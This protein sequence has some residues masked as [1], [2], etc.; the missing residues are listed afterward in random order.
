[1]QDKK[2]AE[3]LQEIIDK[4]KVEEQEAE[5]SEYDEAD[6][7]DFD[8]NLNDE[9]P[10]EADDQ[11]IPQY[12]RTD[13][14]KLN[15][16][17]PSEYLT[18]S[19]KAV[20]ESCENEQLKQ[21][22][23]LNRSKNM[24][25]MQMYKRVKDLLIEC[26]SD[27]TKQE[28][29]CR[30]MAN[31]NKK[32]HP[33]VWRLGSPYFKTADNFPCPPNADTLCK[34]KK[35]EVLFYDMNLSNKWV[36][37][38]VI[39]LIKG[40][41]FHYKMV[42]TTDI[43]KQINSIM[44]KDE[45]SI[46]E[47]DK[48]KIEA[49]ETKL[50]H[51]GETYPAL[52][53]ESVIDW[54]RISKNLFKERYVSDDCEIYWRTYVH[55]NINKSSWTAEESERL[56]QLVQEHNF[57]NWD[58]IASA[59]G[60]NRSGFIV[61]SYYFKK[62]HPPILPGKFTPEENR[63]LSALVEKYREGDYIPWTQ[64]TH[65][66]KGRVRSQV[67]HRYKY[68]LS[69]ENDDIH[70]NR[71]T[72][73][74]DVLLMVLVERF[75]SRFTKIKKHFPNRSVP[76][77]KARYNSNLRNVV[78]KGS[79]TLKEDQIILSFVE[80]HGL[81]SWN[82]LV[83]E[84]NRSSSQIRQRYNTLMKFQATNPSGD[85]ENAPRR[86]F[87]GLAGQKEFDYLRYMVEKFKDCEVIPTLPDIERMLEVSPKPKAEPLQR[88]SAVNE[89]LTRVMP[90]IAIDDLITD[91]FS[92]SM[93]IK[94]E[95]ADS[96]ADY[97]ETAAD[98]IGSILTTFQ[99]ELH[100]PTKFQEDQ[101]LDGIDVAILSAL[102]RNTSAVKD[103][104]V[105]GGEREGVHSLV[106]PN[107]NTVVGMRSLLIKNQ[108]YKNNCVKRE[109]QSDDFRKD[110]MER[111]VLWCINN[112]MASLPADQQQQLLTE[113]SVFTK[114]FFAM[115]KLPAMLS[116]VTPAPALLDHLTTR[117][118]ELRTYQKK[119]R[120]D[121]NDCKPSI[122]ELAA[123]VNDVDNNVKP[124]L[125]IAEQLKR[126]INQTLEDLKH[127]KPVKRPIGASPDLTTQKS[128]VCDV[129]MKKCENPTVDLEKSDSKLTTFFQRKRSRV[130]EP[131][132]LISNSSTM[133]KPTV[134]LPK[135]RIVEEE[136]VDL[137]VKKEPKVTHQKKKA[138]AKRMD[139]NMTNI[140]L[141]NS[142]NN[143]KN[144]ILS[145]KKVK[146]QGNFDMAK[147][148]LVLGNDDCDSAVM[149]TEDDVKDLNMLN[150]VLKQ[151]SLKGEEEEENFEF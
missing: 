137:L 46:T 96:L 140:N 64:I 56:K 78:K 59:L 51:L 28:E 38:D 77:L 74:E 87:A 71:F 25:L 29:Y 88:K 149:T 42:L 68:Y 150:A 109:K 54:E 16:Y 1:M 112:H 126:R 131:S 128:V 114:R 27:I 33:K 3:K 84:L 103:E 49:L 45:E 47:E 94:F 63:K 73:A 136:P 75:G 108:I 86:R 23:V 8:Y 110:E 99:A 130:K 141:S 151:R 26:L 98:A 101:R 61:C 83:P 138:S 41:A 124:K 4:Y 43:N 118:K 36:H 119:P 146:K 115:F 6:Y 127:F 82:Q 80:K 134:V 11:D 107:L 21:L 48:A 123:T 2:D 44:A 147:G 143:V 79:F 85:L 57:Q 105:V 113:R 148:E 5:D 117:P 12:S 62:L 122:S 125:T 50:K 55:P 40:V 32:Y 100:I 142:D 90:S 22:L 106:P 91:Y 18:P 145:P 89:R 7:A 24:Q 10:F 121:T 92:G 9:D 20:I 52:G 111:Q 14:T 144:S 129:E 19:E 116:L 35:G 139:I 39:R 31:C 53:N 132:H 95:E 69:I 120:I 34:V 102:V 81:K 104:Y 13:V 70:K 76:Q 15:T 65:H 30:A 58:Q 37:R 67:F 97:V 17:A 66:F 133:N 135:K 93:K 60:T 72:E